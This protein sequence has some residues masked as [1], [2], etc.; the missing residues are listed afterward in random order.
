MYIF[1]N[2]YFHNEVPLKIQQFYA[3]M[4]L[5]ASEALQFRDLFH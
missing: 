2:W 1:L 4:F 3:E 5:K